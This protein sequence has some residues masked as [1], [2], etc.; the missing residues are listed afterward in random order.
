MLLQFLEKKFKFDHDTTIGVEFGSKIITV[1]GKPIKLQIWDTVIV[2]SFRLGRKPSNPS[3]APTTEGPSESSWSTTSPIESRLTISASGSMKLV[4]MPTTKSVL[5]WWATNQICKAS[6]QW[7][8]QEGDHLR[9][10]LQYRQKERTSLYGVFCQERSKH[11][12]RLWAHVR[13]HCE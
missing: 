9:R 11:R 12:G 8:M 13:D 10:G 1:D 5:C 3:P 6:N 7:A 2:A 4:P